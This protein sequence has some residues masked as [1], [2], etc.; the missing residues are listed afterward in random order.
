M[1][2]AYTFQA[3]TAFSFLGGTVTLLMDLAEPI[4]PFAMVSTFV[5]LG[6]ALVFCLLSLRP[7][8][9]NV[10]TPAFIVSLF[11]MALSGGIWIWQGMT[12]GGQEK[13]ILASKF[14]IPAQM[15][16]SMAELLGIQK[17]I[18]VQAEATAVNTGQ[19]ARNTEKLAKET[20]VIRR[21]IESLKKETSNN[22]HKELRNL[23]YGLTPESVEAAVSARDY[24]ALELYKKAGYVFPVWEIVLKNLF[25]GEVED[26]KIHVKYF[27]H[28]PSRYCVNEAKWG[29]SLQ[30]FEQTFARALLFVDDKQGFLERAAVLCGQD[31]IMD[32]VYDLQGVPLQELFLDEVEELTRDE[33][34]ILSKKMLKEF[35]D[36]L[37]YLEGLTA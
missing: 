32:M 36:A 13:G 26:F 5:F 37:A 21:E 9:R 29:V 20:I 8:M 12:P 24:T 25:H 30:Y 23:G 10:S 22:P 2:R 4:F 11:M 31:H 19:T 28:A 17:E 14:E 6:G 1:I 16:S 15:Q 34:I 3:Y 27:G 7:T 18:L 33:A 35:Q